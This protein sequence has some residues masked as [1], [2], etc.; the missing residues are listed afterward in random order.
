MPDN[1]SWKGRVEQKVDDVLD[2]C[3]ENRKDIK[4]LHKEMIKVATLTDTNSKEIR[5]LRRWKEK[6][7]NPGTV[8]GIFISVGTVVFIV[9]K[10]FGDK[11]GGII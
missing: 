5:S 11:M 8:F 6:I 4:Y 10:L 7:W 2:I 9:L 1:N 3:K